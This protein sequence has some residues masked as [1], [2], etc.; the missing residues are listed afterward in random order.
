MARG[1][2]TAVSR[3]KVVGSSGRQLCKP[4]LELRAYEMSG[5]RPRRRLLKRSNEDGRTTHASQRQLSSAAAPETPLPSGASALQ[6]AGFGVLMVHRRYNTTPSESRDVD[7]DSVT[8]DVFL[9]FV[10]RSSVF[11]FVTHINPST[12]RATLNETTAP[13]I[14]RAPSL[15]TQP[16]LRHR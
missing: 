3:P 15:I 16:A 6:I 2:G 10:I 4:G 1:C 9:R 5:R 7:S 13:F 11:P 14:R 8:F 12:T